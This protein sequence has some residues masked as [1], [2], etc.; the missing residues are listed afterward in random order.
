[1]P[2]PAAVHRDGRAPCR[3][4][5]MRAQLD[6]STDPADYPFHH[7]IRVRFAETDAMAVMHHGAYVTF[8]EE[9]R[10]EY[11]RSLGRPYGD[12]R[13][14]GLDLTVLEVVVQYRRSA[15]FDDLVDVHARVSVARGATLQ[16]DYLLTIGDEVCA[17]GCTVHGVVD[18]QGRA[19]RAPGWLRELLG[20]S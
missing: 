14:E 3:L 4:P 19:T 20:A 13:A 9:A 7:P 17:L 2:V 11:L 12:L 6:I 5:A 1:M 8:L 16:I 10:V 18:H 15:R